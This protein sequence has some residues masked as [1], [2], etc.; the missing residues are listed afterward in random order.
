MAT[1]KILVFGKH[2][3]VGSQLV[4]QLAGRGEY[5][6]IA[7]DI[8]DVDLTDSSATRALVLQHQPDWVINTSAHTAVDKA[9]S[10]AELAYQLNATAPR[11]IA[12]ACHEIGAAMVHY[13][14]DFQWRSNRAL[15]GNGYS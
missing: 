13:S 6:V 12:A 8:E 11:V 7:T 15:H 4:S 5:S 14:T 1:I 9:E 3:Q 10:E 2:G